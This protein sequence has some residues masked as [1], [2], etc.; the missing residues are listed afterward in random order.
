ML[1]INKLNALQSK[2]ILFIQLSND[3]EKC[4]CNYADAI[5]LIFFV[6]YIIAKV[7]AVIIYILNDSKVIVA[8]LNNTKK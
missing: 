4:N 8:Q 6:F 1:K 5:S 3:L 2:V 7:I